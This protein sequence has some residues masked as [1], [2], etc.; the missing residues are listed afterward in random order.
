MHSLGQNPVSR[1]ELLHLHQCRA[2]LSFC[3]WPLSASWFPERLFSPKQSTIS[4]QF[5][6]LLPCASYFRNPN[7]SFKSLVWCDTLIETAHP[8]QCSH[9]RG[10]YEFRNEVHDCIFSHS[11]QKDGLDLSNV[12]Q[13][14]EIR[15]TAC[16]VTS[17][18][19]SIGGAPVA[20]RDLQHCS[21]RGPRQKI[22]CFLWP[23]LVSETSC[24]TLIFFFLKSKG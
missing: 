18:H 3:L 1:E 11:V 17:C 5:C 24:R 9:Y 20:P 2:A 6:R 19:G 22:C 16:R 4:W 15:V 23:Y 21:Y 8:F 7:L 13:G 14:S 10:N 12:T